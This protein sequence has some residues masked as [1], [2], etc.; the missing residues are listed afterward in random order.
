[1]ADKNPVE[2]GGQESSPL[3]APRAPVSSALSPG[4]LGSEGQNRMLQ[5][6]LLCRTRQ[7]A[8]PTGHVGKQPFKQTFCE[9]AIACLPVVEEDL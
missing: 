1:V 9:S 8:D 3:P 5:I 4:S 2:Q 6:G 7:I